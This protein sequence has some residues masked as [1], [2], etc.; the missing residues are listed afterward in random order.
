MYKQIGIC[1]FS[2]MNMFGLKFVYGHAD[3][4]PCPNPCHFI[5]LKY[6][7]ALKCSYHMVQKDEDVLS[8]FHAWCIVALT[9]IA[10][11]SKLQPDH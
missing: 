11:F 2:L 6:S 10:L 3:N 5:L 1:P 4:I 7:I 8:M 9:S